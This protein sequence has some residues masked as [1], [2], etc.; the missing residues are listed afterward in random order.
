[1]EKMEA[2]SVVVSGDSGD[3]EDLAADKAYPSK[4]L[5]V[6]RHER[7]HVL[8]HLQGLP[9]D[10]EDCCITD[11]VEAM[12]AA[13]EDRGLMRLAAEYGTGMHNHDATKAKM[14]SDGV[15]VE[16]GLTSSGFDGF[17]RQLWTIE[18]KRLLT[19]ANETW[20]TKSDSK[21]TWIKRA[22]LAAK[23]AVLPAG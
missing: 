14:C 22:L 13:G 5:W 2:S 7:V 12:G 21:Q 16:D 9:E 8:A 19:E 6:D 4:W 23:M 11:V 17:D 3:P 20:M 18:T 10:C 15:A 1:M